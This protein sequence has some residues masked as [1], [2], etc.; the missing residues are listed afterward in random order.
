MQDRLRAA[1]HGDA[2][3]TGWQITAAP[4]WR[5][6]FESAT[7]VGQDDERGQILV[8]T[9]Q[10]VRYPAADARMPH[11]NTAGVHLIHRLRMVDAISVKAAEHAQLVGMFCDVRK[12]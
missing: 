3:I 6:T 11:Q 2:L 5:A 9:S 8:L 1:A 12:K 10:T 4:S 7:G